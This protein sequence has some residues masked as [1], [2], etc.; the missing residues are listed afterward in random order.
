MGNPSNTAEWV[1]AGAACVAVILTGISVAYLYVQHRQSVSLRLRGQASKVWAIPLPGI[2]AGVHND[3]ELPIY[4]VSVLLARRDTGEHIT[5][6]SGP[7]PKTFLAPKGA[8]LG[9]F[10]WMAGDTPDDP[11]KL[12]VLV[13]FTDAAQQ[14]WRRSFDGQLI[15]LTKP[16]RWRDKRRAWARAHSPMLRR[17]MRP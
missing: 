13:D 7:T 8:W 15:H 10:Q 3:S 2:H 1:A 9:L 16:K 12:S 11:E 4:N 5:V 17:L 6:S 14:Q